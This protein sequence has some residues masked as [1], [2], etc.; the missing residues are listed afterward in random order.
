MT[1][2]RSLVLVLLVALAGCN[3]ALGP[4]A[5]D[6]GGD[7]D[8][9]NP[10]LPPGVT[11]DSVNATTL[12]D[13]HVESLD[14][15]SFTLEYNL[16]ASSAQADVVA[17]IGPN[18]ERAA[19]HIEK[20]HQTEAYFFVDGV[21]Y[22][23]DERDGETQYRVVNRSGADGAPFADR[24]V[25][26]HELRILLAAGEWKTSGTTDCRAGTCWVL[27][28]TSVNESSQLSDAS[29]FDGRAVVAP[30]GRVE[31][32]SVTIERPNDTGNVTITISD[33]GATTVTRPEWV[34]EANESGTRVGFE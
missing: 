23:L 17:T 18:R 19:I 28:A 5:S 34:D 29:R 33:V 21:Q 12:M 15:E 30:S 22:E 2:V 20:S 31:K 13:A 16:S 26:P 9:G 4:I 32:I 24:Y 14:G 11:D 10:S 8:G 27:D 6:N 3:G 1:D 7:A 25:R